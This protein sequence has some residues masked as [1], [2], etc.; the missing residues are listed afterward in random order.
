MDP[1]EILGV[2]R[3][4]SRAEIKRAWRRRAFELHPDRGGDVEE[5]KKV[6]EAYEFLVSRRQTSPRPEVERPEQR[7]EP[8]Q[9]HPAWYLVPDHVRFWFSFAH[10]FNGL[11]Q[12]LV[13]PGSIGVPILLICALLF[14]KPKSEDVVR[15]ISI[16]SVSGVIAWTFRSTF[17]DRLRLRLQ[18]KYRD[19]R[20]RE[21]AKE[22]LA[23][24]SEGSTHGRRFAAKKRQWTPSS[25]PD[26]RGRAAGVAALIGVL[27]AITVG[28]IFTAEHL[29]VHPGVALVFYGA[30]YGVPLACTLAYV[31][32]GRWW[33]RRASTVRT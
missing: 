22:T 23:F 8:A 10:F 26:Y 27:F 20:E 5:F 28:A 1:W 33:A 16:A 21:S 17:W 15:M 2:P 14:G 31:F 29:T 11:I 3:N 6:L 32:K 4:A 24:A 18:H 9:E 12:F 19:S 30:L 13:R 25:E 7:R